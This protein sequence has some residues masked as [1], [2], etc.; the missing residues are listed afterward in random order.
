MASF[1]KAKLNSMEE[2]RRREH[3]GLIW[4]CG[5]PI[6]TSFLL[7]VE[8]GRAIFP[9]IDQ[10]FSS[11]CLFQNL[12]GIDCPFCG[13]SRSF[14]EIAHFNFS[15]AINYNGAGVAFFLFLIFQIF[16]RAYLMLRPYR[17]TPSQKLTMIPLYLLLAAV[18]GQWALKLLSHLA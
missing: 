12:L 14:I 18:F 2:F 1:P 17:R 15:Q 9:I 7:R 5:L 6:L 13:L 11:L 3:F 8:N 10:G 16:Y 4:L